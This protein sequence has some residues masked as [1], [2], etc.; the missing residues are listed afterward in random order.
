[1]RLEELTKTISSRNI[2]VVGD[3]MLDE[4]LWGNIH[5]ISPEAPVPL[6]KVDYQTHSLGGAGNIATNLTAMGSKVWLA[7]IVGTDLQAVKIAEL[8]T[9]NPDISAY[10]YPCHDRP[11]T[12]KIRIIARGQ[13][14]LRA[15][16]EE[17]HPIP[18]QAEDSIIQWVQEHL[19]SMHACVLSDYAKG[20]L[21][22][23]L[24]HS[25]IFLCK[26]SNIPV[27]VDP[28]GHSYSRYRGAT[29]ITPNLEEA[30]LAA[31]DEDQD[32]TLTEVADHLLQEIRDGALLITQGSKGM[33]LFRHSFPAVNIPAEAQVIDDVTGAGDTVVAVLALLL[34]I[35]IDMAVAAKLA[36]YA[37]GIVVG[38]V[39]TASISLQELYPEID[40][41]QL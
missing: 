31:E 32:L 16:R 22:E 29:V 30:H 4:Y 1:M 7:G 27:V 11:T 20:V 25:L 28:K 33:S 40:R 19:V 15:D 18:V 6:V 2:L 37:A 5:R 3:V 12:T 9:L 24:I 36:N 26:E 13:Q 23:K 21:T 17:Q 35:G 8:L 41:L 39:G 14:L 34:A 10:L 38:K